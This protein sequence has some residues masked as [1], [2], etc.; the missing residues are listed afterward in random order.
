M[1]ACSLVFGCLFITNTILAQ[2]TNEFWSR[3][4]LNKKLNENWSLASDFYYR[5]QSGRYPNQP[6][7]F[8]RPLTVGARAWVYYKFPRQV[9]IGASPIAYFRN[10]F[11][12]PGGAE[13]IT[14]EIRTAASVT[15]GFDIGTMNNRNRLLYEA[16]WLHFK[17]LQHRL[18][19][20]NT[21]T[22]PVYAIRESAAINGFLSNEV[23][24]KAQEKHTSF[25]QDRM[26]IALQYRTKK[27]EATIGFQLTVQAHSNG[28]IYRRQFVLGFSFDL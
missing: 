15:K 16:R 8:S 5:T 2:H 23:F 17:T 28:Y 19:L 4:V 9:M 18:R 26:F 20:Q 13:A 22:V 12:E 21:L 3:I 11:I 10:V 14:K 27:A 24:Y 1:K 6:G 25:D 7:P